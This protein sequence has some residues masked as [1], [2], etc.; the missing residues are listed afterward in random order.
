MLRHAGSDYIGRMQSKLSHSAL[1]TFRTCPRKFKFAYVDKTSVPKRLFA[2]NHLGNT[3]HRQLKKAYQWAADGRLYPLADMLAAYDWDWQ[4]KIKQKV[5]PSFEGGSVDDDIAT[6]RR[7][8]QNYY[9]RFQ[10]FDQGVL[11]LAE[12]KVDFELPNCPTGFTTRIDRLTKLGDGEAEICD[13]K[14]SKSMPAGPKDDSFRLQMATYQLAVQQ[15]FPQFEKITLTQYYLRHQEVVSYQMRPDEIDE[16]AEQFRTEVFDIARSERT[17]N[18]PTKEGGQCNWCDYFHLCPAK[19]H[20]RVMEA[21][22]DEEAPPEYR[23][24]AVLADEFLRK[25]TEAKRLKAELEAL[26]DELATSARNLNVSKFKG[27]IGQVSVTIKSVEK[28]PSKSTEPQKYVDLVSLVRS[29]DE[30]TREACLKPDEASLLSLY[31]KNRLAPQ[32]KDALA[33][34]IKLTEQTTIRGK[35]DQVSGEDD[36]DVGD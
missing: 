17:D 8:L 15:A 1:D 7:L 3:V 4:G 36:E 25:D 24:A 29:W 34:L 20:Q 23:E 28:L 16:L 10:P 13:Y 12:R 9:A 2:F 6:G 14:T 31:H 30:D 33:A 22:D 26:K 35:L 11:I 18:W 5:V 19:R 21:V 27:S 32:Q